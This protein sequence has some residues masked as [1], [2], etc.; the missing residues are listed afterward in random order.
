MPE[1]R[2]YGSQ[3]DRILEDL[4][5]GYTGF[6]NY[7]RPDQLERGMLASSKNGRLGLNGEWQV[8]PGID[9]VKAP[10]ASGDDV[11]RIPTNAELEADPPVVGLLPTTIRR[12]ELVASVMELFLD[13]LTEQG[14]EFEVGQNIT[15]EGLAFTAPQSDPNGTFV[16]T[17]VVNDPI[18][19]INQ[20]VTFDFTGIDTTYR[21]PV[22]LP[23]NLAFNL[24]LVRGS[25]IAGYNMLLDQGG[26]SAVYAST[27]YSNPNDS[28][29]QWVLLGSNVSALAINLADPTVTYDLPYKDGETAPPLSDMI[30]AFNKVFL[31]RDGQTAL[32]WD[33]S[34]ANVE[35]TELE[36][37]RTYII[38]A[39]GDTDW[40]D[41][42]GTTGITYAVGDTVDVE[43]VSL[44]GT[45][46]AR[47]GFSLVAS[48]EY[49]QPTQIICA[50]GDFAIVESRA[51][52]HQTDGV[53]VG[54]TIT[55]LGAETRE[56]DQTSG[57]QI[58]SEF[59][60]AKLYEEGP[61]SAIGNAAGDQVIGPV[62]V[63]GDYEGLRKVTLLLANTF[64]IGE[65]IQL[66]GFST[67]AG[68]NG[69][70]FVADRTSSSFSFYTADYNNNNTPLAG[71][72]HLADGFE[73]WIQAD[74]IDT[75]ITDGQSLLSTPVFTR[76]VSVSLGFTHMP[77]PPYATYHQRRL[78]MP[79]RYTVENAE[80]QYTFRNNLDEIIVSDILDAD[81]YDQIY[82]QY[83]F[84]AGTADFNV[85]LLSFADDKLVVFNRNSIHLVQGSNP[86]NSSVQ[87][88]TNEVGCLARKTIVQIGNNV[89]FLSDNGIYGANFQDLY[90]LRGSELPLSSSIQTTIDKINRQHWDQSVAVYFNNRYYIAVPI[91]GST[92]NN[93]ILV[94]NFI[95]KQWESV[96]T[97][98]D[99]D[100]DIENLIVAGKKSDRAVY[101]VNALGG[102]HK[103]DAR[104]DG[105][106]RLA[107]TIPV[108]GGQDGVIYNIPAEVTTRQFTLNDFG[109]KRWSE[110]EMHVQSSDSEQ[111]DFDLLAEVENIDAEVNL[112][113]LSSYIGGS[114]DIDEDVSV[115]G[116]IGNRRGYGIQFRINNTQGR[117]R[118]R[119]IKVSGAPASRS[120]TSVQ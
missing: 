68:I 8:R 81:T 61:S 92:V 80:G 95:N 9:L 114:L 59:V 62:E 107:T 56:A 22:V 50:P 88:I 7:L 18:N 6:N 19:P 91:D 73:F 120:T 40:N 98:S 36:V 25:A 104:L 90:N 110:F 67:S 77:A 71:T 4:D 78:V 28:A 46:T 69:A 39:L 79:Y 86:A 108:E 101:A 15:V 94:F 75:H 109:R 43:V 21:G 87:L 49:S 3:D 100:W 17:S 16:V 58:G 29:S 10:F 37:G 31:F 55:V 5:M 34:F 116:R 32:E 112:N 12:A 103:V 41:V 54:S 102:L 105:V 24:T 118:V 27:S 44:A 2:T 84:N 45:G 13:P 52:V 99:V 65:P 119:G 64:D 96:D 113:T 63:G 76:K 60:V 57:L 48:G 117:P 11:L 85:G 106:D 115:R 35:S 83:R 72:V 26:I 66:A 89:M 1:Y 20:K 70:R 53:S 93:T 82:G 42:A 23:I 38:T 97:T 51:I 47:S 111:S 14:H 74:S 33:G 30:Q